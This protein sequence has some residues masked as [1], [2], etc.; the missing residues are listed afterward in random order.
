VA[1]TAGPRF[2]RPDGAEIL[3]LGELGLSTIVRSGET[4][5]VFGRTTVHGGDTTLPYLG[6]R[7]LF[8]LRPEV[9]T[10][11]FGFFV[12]Q[13][14]GKERTDYSVESCSFWGCSTTGRRARDGGLA[15]GFTVGTS[16][17]VRAQRPPAP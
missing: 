4:S 11:V 7:L 6:A 15:V 3:L 8:G 14:L 16:T 12:Q 17:S 9:S 10:V 2:A 1:A 13:T 5:G